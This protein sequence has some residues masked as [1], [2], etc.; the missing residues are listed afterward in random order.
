MT[1]RADQLDKWDTRFLALARHVSGWSRDP[2]TKVGA[3]IVNKRRLVVGIGYNGLPRGVKDL[4]QR[5]ERPAKYLYTQHAETNA[6]LNASGDV[7]GST[8]F[9]T[10]PPC[11]HCAGFIIQAGIKEVVCAAPDSGLRERFC[12]S[13]EAAEVMFTEAGIIVTEV[14]GI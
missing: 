3:V 12:D 13:F 5:L 4:R 2:S 7:R 14:E 11:S 9:V 8:I 6:I 10:A 1:I